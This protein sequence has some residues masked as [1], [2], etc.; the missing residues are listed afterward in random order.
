M[1]S[2]C[3]TFTRLLTR[4]RHLDQKYICHLIQVP[5]VLTYGLTGYVFSIIQSTAT[6]LNNNDER[7]ISQ[8]RRRVA[9][10]PLA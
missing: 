6:S 5:L 3:V 4:D 2:K 7:D 10:T 1:T 8:G 9:N